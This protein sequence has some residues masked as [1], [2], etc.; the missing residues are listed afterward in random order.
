MNKLFGFL[1]MILLVGFTSCTQDEIGT[2]ENFTDDTTEKI[3]GDARV[4]DK[5]CFEFVFPITISFANGSKKEVV[6]YDSLK[7]AIKAWKT[8]NPDTKERPTIAYPYAVTTSEGTIV[9][10]TTDAEK[11]ALLATCRPKGKDHPGK[12]NGDGR[13]CFTVNFPFSI[14]T[15]SATI[16]INSKEDIKSLLNRKDRKKYNYVF[17]IS[18]TLKDGTIKSISSL[19]D[20]TALKEECR[21]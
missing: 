19:T 7:A 8:A 12:G 5:G 16:V 20:L 13:S 6:S 11:K 14:K 2:T 4:G 15:D 9:T 21:K 3:C 17:P 10:V 1:A 18:I